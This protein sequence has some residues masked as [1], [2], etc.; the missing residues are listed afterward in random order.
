M[1]THKDGKRT[2]AVA[3]T[4]GL[5]ATALAVGGTI[6]WLTASNTVSNTF[7]V[8]Q[9]TKPVDPDLRAVRA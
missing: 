8:G 2:P 7:T 4:A 6:A 1:T 3:I 9:I 5:L